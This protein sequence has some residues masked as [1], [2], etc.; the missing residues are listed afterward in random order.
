MDLETFVMNK[1][2][3]A[4]SEIIKSIS[5]DQINIINN[6]HCR[7]WNIFHV[8]CVY[9]SLDIVKLLVENGADYNSKTSWRDVPLYLVIVN[10]KMDIIKY[11]LTLD[12]LNIY[13]KTDINFNINVYINYYGI[14]NFSRDV[15]KLLNEYISRNI[16]QLL[17]PYL[18]DDLIYVIIKYYYHV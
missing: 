2:Y 7:G 3:D 12:N 16:K 17:D 5:P 9:S 14:D 11:L 10:K 18:C 1:N 13:N 6:T 15:S 4:L 8:A